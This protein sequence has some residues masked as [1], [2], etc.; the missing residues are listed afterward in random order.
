MNEVHYSG[1]E[2]DGETEFDFFHAR[3]LSGAQQ[4]FM[5]ADPGNAG[6]D[7]FD[8]QRWNAYAYIGNNPLARI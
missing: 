8:P 3:Y 6:A 4:R 5:S 2:H 7:L 1:Q